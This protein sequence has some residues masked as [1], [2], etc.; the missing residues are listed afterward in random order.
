[1]EIRQ[2]RPRPALL[3]PLTPQAWTSYGPGIGPRHHDPGPPG[4]EGLS[5]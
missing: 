5:R 3:T 2:R 4:P 1:M